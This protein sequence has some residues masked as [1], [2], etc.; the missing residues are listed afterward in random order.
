MYVHGGKERMSEKQLEF[1]DSTSKGPDGLLSGF[2]ALDLTNQ[3]GFACGKIL[4]AL[5]VDTIKIERPG[6]DPS[7][8]MPSFL[9]SDK[10]AE[11]G[12]YWLAFN[13]D[14][15]GITLNIETNQGRDLFK[16]LAKETDFVI[17]SFTPGYLDGLGIGYEALSRINPRIIVTSI[18]PFG[19]KGPHSGYKGGEIVVAAMGGSMDNTGDPDRA[20]LKEPLEAC[21]YH[22]NVAAATGTVMAHYFRETTGE[23][24]QVD[25]SVQEVTASRSAPNL[26]LWD[27]DKRL[28]KRTGPFSRF[29]GTTVRQVW[30]C[31][32]GFVSWG[33]FAGVLGEKTNL[34]LSRWMDDDGLPNPLHE[35]TDWKALDLPSLPR[36]QIDRFET[37]IG[38]FFLNHTKKELREEGQKRKINAPVLDGPDDMLKNIQ[39][40]ARNYWRGVEHPEWGMKLTYPGY[41]FLC[42]ETDNFVKR[43]APFV[44]E[45][46]NEIYV[47]ELG[48]SAD[49]VEALRQSG[50]V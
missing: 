38:A 10:N 37:A 16:K 40:E 9:G 31:K 18:T 1:N 49:A 14:K 41:F 39:L 22:G 47:K 45:H 42:S 36:E 3:Q 29:G 46:N 11:K 33:M 4:A 7:R 50:V 13:T 48:M 8:N 6:G 35:I 28:I 43:R 44:G 32:D 21:Y 20:P 23:G 27:F 17:E 12:L 30:P 24:Q 26:I 2:R 34:A 19:Q 15:R 5:G 25:I